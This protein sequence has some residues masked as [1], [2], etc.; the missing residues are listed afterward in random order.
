MTI[1]EIMK[2]LTRIQNQ[3]N[4]KLVLEKADKA[5]SNLKRARTLAEQAEATLKWAEQYKGKTLVEIF[6]DEAGN[7]V[8]EAAELPVKE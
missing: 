8:Y 1:D 5:V 3:S 7:H 2:G 6:A 4:S